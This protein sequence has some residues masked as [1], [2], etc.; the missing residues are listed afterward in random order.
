MADAV[1]EGARQAGAHV[2]I[3]RVPEEIASHITSS[4]RCRRS[5]R[6]MISLPTTR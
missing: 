2:E 1:A 5:Q 4:I 3:K 6:S